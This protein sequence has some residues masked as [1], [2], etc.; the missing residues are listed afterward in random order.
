[1]AFNV[2]QFRSNLLFDGARPNL[3]EVNLGFPSVVTDG[4]TSGQ[5]ALFMAKAAQLPGSSIGTVPMY[6]FGRELKMAGNRTFTDWTVTIVN[7]EDFAIRNSLEVWL[8]KINSHAGNIRAATTNTPLGYTADSS[9]V[10]YGKDGSILKQINMVGMFPI[11]ISPIDL[12]WDQNDTIEE[13]QVTFAYQ[14]WTSDV[15]DS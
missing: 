6:Y 11:D 2:S 9:V 12:G 14:Y 15:T 7:D 5:K 1:M 3:F 4:T 13:Y 8:G 10:Q